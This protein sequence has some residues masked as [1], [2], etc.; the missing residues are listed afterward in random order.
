MNFFV[1]YSRQEKNWETVGKFF[2]KK[3][4]NFVTMSSRGRRRLKAKAK[5]INISEVFFV[6]GRLYEFL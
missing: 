3:K 1:N 2:T 5:E 4:T 6:G